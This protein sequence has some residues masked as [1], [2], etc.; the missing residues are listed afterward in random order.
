MCQENADTIMYD[1]CW[2]SGVRDSLLT[3]G[4]LIS[5]VI[6][7]R[8]NVLAAQWRFDEFA[9]R[10]FVLYLQSSIALVSAP[11]IMQ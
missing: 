11:R 3:G 2:P 5:T 7:E 8:I 1:A 4:Q 10:W 6:A 9:F